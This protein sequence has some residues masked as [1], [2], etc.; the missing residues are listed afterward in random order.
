VSVENSKF[1]PPSTL[2]VYLYEPSAPFSFQI[3]A[4]AQYLEELLEDRLEEGRV[5]VRDEFLQNYMITHDERDVKKRVA[6]LIGKCRIEDIKSQRF[7]SEHSEKEQLFYAAMELNFL[8]GVPPERSRSYLYHGPKLMD[9]Y[10]RFVPDNEKTIEHLHII[11]TDR[12]F[13][14][15][16]FADARYHARAVMLG[17]P[18]MISMPGIVEAPARPREYYI[19]RHLYASSGLSIDELEAEFAGRYLIYKDERTLEVLKGY[20]LQTLFYSLFRDPFC[21]DASCRLYNAHWQSELLGSQIESAK[22]CKRHDKMIRKYVATSE[23]FQ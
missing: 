21:T 22:L 13:C 16:S 5:E 7:A 11:F 23:K 18:N 17:F 6:Q 19:K 3:E 20:T 1:F 9:T 8:D 15:W 2:Y 12:L 14:T 10:R 4:L